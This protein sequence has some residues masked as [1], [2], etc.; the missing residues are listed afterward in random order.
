MRYTLKKSSLFRVLKYAVTVIL[1]SHSIILA[2]QTDA[3]SIRI[4]SLIE[5]GIKN[6]AFPGAQVL[7][8]KKDSIQ[9]HKAYGFHTYDSLNQVKKTDLYDLASVTKVLAGTLAFM[10]LYELYDIDLDAAIS[11]YIPLIKRSNKKF[12]TFKEV[13]SHS[14]GWLPYIA[15]QNLIR[16]KN[17]EFKARTLNNRFSKRY[18]D[19]ISDSLFLFKN[20][21]RKIMRRIRRTKMGDVGTY[22]Y[23]GLWFFLLPELTQK[24]SGLSFEAFLKKHFYN[25]LKLERFSFNP[26]KEFS[27]NEIV[28][29]EIDSLFRKGLVQGWV[30]DEAA[31]LMG[32]VSGNAGLFANAAS[33]SPLLQLFL[34]EGEIDGRRL[35]KAETIALFTQK[36]YPE[37]ENRRG[38]GFDKPD[39]SDDEKTYP[40]KLASS[41]SYGHSG[42]TG[43]FIWVDPLRECFLIFLSNRVYPSRMQTGIYDLNIRGQLLDYVLEY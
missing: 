6:V 24:L 25:P 1:F 5:N 3:F 38:L 39:N 37:S 13:L 15:H 9:F 21:K 16:K 33:I 35:L 26:S 41:L 34:N 23:S 30:H 43:T 29:T 14:S 42:F 10:K 7:I 4:D 28:P 18:P 2:Q 22:N 31:A 17:G 8:F 19:Q 40:S 27:K 36:A 20:Y 12:S 11:D 32:G